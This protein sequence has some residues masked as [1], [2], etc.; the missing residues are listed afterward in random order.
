MSPTAKISTKDIEA[1]GSGRISKAEENSFSKK[2][3]PFQLTHVLIDGR[4]S[5]I[6]KGDNGCFSSSVFMFRLMELL[7]LAG[8][9]A[10]TVCA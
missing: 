10:E 1:E 4:G 5:L 2:G 7:Q 3:K 6:G 8:A 9:D